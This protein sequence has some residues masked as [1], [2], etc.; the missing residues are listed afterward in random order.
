MSDV[1][2]PMPEAPPPPPPG[3]DPDPDPASTSPVPTSPVPTIP[4]AVPSPPAL[5]PAPPPPR[6]PADVVAVLDPVISQDG[7]GKYTSYRVEVRP[8]GPPVPPEAAD[9]AGGSSPTPPPP[10]TAATATSPGCTRPWDRSGQGRSFLPSPTSRRRP[11]SSRSSWRS[12]G[13]SSSCS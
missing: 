5:P 1:S 3:P 13:G 4:T 12:G 7:M 10:S 6:P 11:D 2:A 8:A 9:A